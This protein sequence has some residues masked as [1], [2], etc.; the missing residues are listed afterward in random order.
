MDLAAIGAA[1][2]LGSIYTVSLAF[3]AQKRMG[4]PI[5]GTADGYRGPAFGGTLTSLLGAAAL[6][7]R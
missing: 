6:T 5:P 1:L 4:S 3:P 7:I 2:A